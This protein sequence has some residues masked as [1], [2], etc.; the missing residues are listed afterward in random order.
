MGTS[1]TQGCTGMARE[2]VG[3]RLPWPTYSSL[4]FVSPSLSDGAIGSSHRSLPLRVPFHHSTVFT[5]AFWGS[6]PRVT[7]FPEQMSRC[8]IDRWLRTIYLWAP[9]PPLHS[10]LCSLLPHPDFHP[11]PRVPI[12]MELRWM[13]RLGFWMPLCKRL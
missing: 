11:I 7:P 1:G 12:L 8:G 2:L 5:C 13:Q 10:G 3:S 6:R 9:P 4:I